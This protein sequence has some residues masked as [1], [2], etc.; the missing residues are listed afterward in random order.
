MPA[1]SRGMRWDTPPLNTSLLPEILQR[2]C[3]EAGGR[4][5]RRRLTACSTPRSGCD[6]LHQRRKRCFITST[7]SGF[8]HKKPHTGTQPLAGGAPSVTALTS[9]PDVVIT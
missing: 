8:D 1:D 9:A 4:L 3:L 5:W 2:A 6:W 7:N